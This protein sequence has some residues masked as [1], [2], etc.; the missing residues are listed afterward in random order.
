MSMVEGHDGVDERGMVR[1]CTSDHHATGRR[2]GDGSVLSEVELPMCSVQQKCLAL[3]VP[4][5]DCKFVFE[6]EWCVGSVPDSASLR[7][8]CPVSGL[9]ELACLTMIVKFAIRIPALIIHVQA[10]VQKM[11]PKDRVLRVFETCSNFVL[12]L[13]VICHH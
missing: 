8:T 11:Y 5:E 1:H 13:R 3:S 2:S 12:T 6:L 9:R 7:R 10:M 4:V